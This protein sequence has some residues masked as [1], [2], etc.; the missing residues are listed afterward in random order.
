MKPELGLPTSR[1]E[2]PPDDESWRLEWQEFAGAIR[3]AT[4]VRS[5]VTWSRPYGWRCVEAAY[6][7]PAAS[8]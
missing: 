8:E 5:P 7:E 3:P 1:I 2:F 4:D 6:A